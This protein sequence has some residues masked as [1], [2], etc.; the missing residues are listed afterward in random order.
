[1]AMQIVSL[2]RYYKGKFGI[3]KI[4]EIDQILMEKISKYV[5]GALNTCKLVLGKYWTHPGDFTVFI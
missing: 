4:V 2:E 3:A 5:R 1:M